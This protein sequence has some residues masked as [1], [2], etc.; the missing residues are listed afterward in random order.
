M[1]NLE[2]VLVLV[3]GALADVVR[4]GAYLADWDDYAAFNAAYERWFPDRLPSR[5]CIGATGLAVGAR[6]ELD[7]VAWR[8][9]GWGEG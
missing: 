1:R 9:G 3:G 7:L 8:A 6:V 4:V 2:R 5:T